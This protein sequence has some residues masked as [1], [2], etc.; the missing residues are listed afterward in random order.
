MEILQRTAPFRLDRTRQAAPQMFEAIREQIVSLALAPGTVLSRADLADHYGV[1]QTPIREA[2]IRL[3]TEGLVD[4][5]PQHATLVSRIDIPGALRAHFLRRAVELE[6]VHEWA[7]MR[8][9]AEVTDLVKALRQHW[10]RQSEAQGPNDLSE[11]IRADHDFHRALY[12]LAGMDDL[13]Q[14]VRQR[15]GHVDRLRRLHLPSPGKTQAVL[16]DHQKI[17][18]AIE[19]QDAEG[20]RRAV[21]QHLAGTLTFVD[22][23]RRT[24]PSFVV[25]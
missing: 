6:L 7:S 9:R 8:P 10:V 13:W 19:R 3:G 1:S 23:V 4:V 21:R 5:F 14:L 18:E 2:L 24:H 20:A 16:A 15:S 12:E 25:G 17:I 22:D 11:F